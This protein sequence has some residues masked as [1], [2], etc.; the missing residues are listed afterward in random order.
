MPGGIVLSFL[1]L[2]SQWQPIS[3]ESLLYVICVFMSLSTEVFNTISYFLYTNFLVYKYI[4]I[5]HH[6]TNKNIIDHFQAQGTYDAYFLYATF[7]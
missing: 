3:Y 5:Y 4:S 1:I 6:P 7:S 2:Q